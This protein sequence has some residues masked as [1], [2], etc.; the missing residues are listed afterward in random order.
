MDKLTLK[1]L[2]TTGKYTFGQP[3]FANSSCSEPFLQIGLKN[4]NE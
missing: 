4:V 3:L 1:K 2:A